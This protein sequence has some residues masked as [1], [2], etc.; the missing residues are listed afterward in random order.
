MADKE[1]KL[2]Q[3]EPSDAPEVADP[4]ADKPNRWST[5]GGA[6]KFNR[7]M[8]DYPPKE[9]EK[10][11][12]HSNDGPREL[13]GWPAFRKA[14]SD[15]QMA[16]SAQRFRDL[17]ADRQAK[18]QDALPEKVAFKNAVLEVLDRVTQAHSKKLD[19]ILKLNTPDY[20]SLIEGDIDWHPEMYKPKDII[21]D[22]GRST[23][24]VRKIMEHA[25]DPE[26]LYDYVDGIINE[27]T[28]Y[29]FF[30]SNDLL[31]AHIRRDF[32]SAFL[33][34][35]LGELH[36]RGL[37]DA[38]WDARF[39]TL[40]DASE[41]GF[42]AY[43]L[44]Q[45]EVLN[46]SNDSTKSLIQHGKT[47]MA[48]GNKV[49]GMPAHATSLQREE[50]GAMACLSE[51][52]GRD[53]AINT[54]E[55]NP[56]P[57]FLLLAHYSRTL[58][59]IRVRQDDPTTD[60]E[61]IKNEASAQFI[62]HYDAICNQWLEAARAQPRLET[63]VEQLA[64]LKACIVVEDRIPEDFGD[65]IAQAVK[66][67]QGV[68]VDRTRD[69]YD[70]DAQ[71][72]NNITPSW[73]TVTA[74][75]MPEYGS[76]KHLNYDIKE[77][78]HETRKFREAISKD[79]FRHRVEDMLS[80]AM[81]ETF[82]QTA[83]P[84]TLLAASDFIAEFT[85]NIGAAL[86]AKGLHD[87]LFMRQMCELRDFAKSAYESRVLLGDWV[88]RET[89]LGSNSPY[90]TICAARGR[91]PRKLDLAGQQDIGEHARQ[92]VGQLAEKRGIPEVM[93]GCAFTPLIHERCVE[94]AEAEIEKELAEETS[95]LKVPQKKAIH[96]ARQ[97][98]QV[99][100]SV[101]ADPNHKWRKRIGY[102]AHD[103][104][105][106]I[107]PKLQAD[108]DRQ[109]AILSDE[110]EE[111]R[112]S[113]IAKRAIEIMKEAMA[114]VT[115][116]LPKEIGQQGEAEEKE[117]DASIIPALNPHNLRIMLKLIDARKIAAEPDMARRH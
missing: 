53:Y 34:D 48:R 26:S 20:V 22:F 54:N 28:N 113:L 68:I 56:P 3:I 61:D 64:K 11:A 65:V 66:S 50:M 1:K 67:A 108:V 55:N 23:S 5:Q 27:D 85:A 15:K 18:K 69:Y 24:V 16:R 33:D 29:L 102:R 96:S 89:D 105:G 80:V 2:K 8:M 25:T 35:V 109:H 84:A 12:P 63:M 100:E 38:S 94:A 75:L 115:P 45:R 103:Y 111:M 79:D 92:Y 72:R 52:L 117:L 110:R 107:P 70:D 97:R 30:K 73:R 88:M 7:G 104:N 14:S 86:D 78:M 57:L 83:H 40:R 99:S 51:I 46:A 44:L 116:E 10:E 19:V 74:T 60:H 17:A 32:I 95:K 43:E 37:M 59:E 76:I 49:Y 114:R 82:F 91:D 90:D 41:Y 13:R 87:E 6:K 31:G 77:L 106:S 4:S 47:W 9:G 98:T 39:M 42:E 21:R 71:Q 36:S 58:A 81:E 93:R 101:K 112:Q 62:D